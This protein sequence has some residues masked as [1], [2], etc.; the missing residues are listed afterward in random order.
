MTRPVVL[1]LTIRTSPN[2]LG[3]KVLRLEYEGYVPMAELELK[4]ICAQVRGPASSSVMCC[5]SYQ[6][7]CSPELSSMNYDTLCGAIARTILL[8]KSMI[9]HHTVAAS[10][11]IFFFFCFWR[12]APFAFGR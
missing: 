11:S 9:L 10:D 4:K 7:D 8:L 3:K 2:T 5:S 12:Q 6:S 1:C